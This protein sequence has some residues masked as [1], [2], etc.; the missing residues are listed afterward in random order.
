MPYAPWAHDHDDML[1]WVRTH[2]IP[3][4]GVTVAEEGEGLLGV[5]ATSQA[6]GT[7]WIDQLYV[8]PTGVARGLGTRLMA[9]AHAQL[10]RPIRL[11]TFQAN[12]GARRFYERQ[13]YR[14]LTQ[15]DGQTNEEKCPD[16][17]YELC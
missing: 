16:V 6:D 3:T 8:I 2:L 12:T 14:V 5:L 9:H 1:K 7:C 11:Y 10:P 13:G 4:G 15:T 17:L